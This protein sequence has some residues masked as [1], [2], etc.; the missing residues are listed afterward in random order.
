MSEYFII[1]PSY[2]FHVAEITY[3]LTKI[4]ASLNPCQVTGL[5]RFEQVLP[6]ARWRSSDAY[7]YRFPSVMCNVTYF[8]KIVLPMITL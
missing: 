3:L 6:R 1:L 4:Q 7:F 5:H 2:F 8:L